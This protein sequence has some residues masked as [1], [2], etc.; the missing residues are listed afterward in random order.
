MTDVLLRRTII[1]FCFVPVQYLTFVFR[2]RGNL[3]EKQID[4]GTDHEE[5]WLLHLLHQAMLAGEDALR[6]II[7]ALTTIDEQQDK[8]SVAYCLLCDVFDPRIY[9]EAV[10]FRLIL[11]ALLYF[12]IESA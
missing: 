2:V 11:K 1:W 5:D 7:D 4:F 9:C 3:I 6:Q 10:S 8:V 12:F